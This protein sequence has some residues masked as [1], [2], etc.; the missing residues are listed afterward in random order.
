VDLDPRDL[1]VFLAVERHGSFGR[2]AVEL[3][4]TQPA[5]SERV[6]HL[7][8]VVGRSL[9]ERTT[10]GASLT[11]A[12]ETLL[13]YARRGVAL[14]EEAVEATR[15]AD[16]VP[17]LVIAV[18]SMFAP[19][20][21]PL[22][23]GALSEL[24]RRVS[25]RDAHSDV[26]TALVLDGSAHVGFA[27]PG[28][29]PPGLRR[30]HLRADPIRCVVA[31]GHPISRARRP[32]TRSLR[33]SVLALNAWGPGSER[34]LERLRGDGVDEWRI[35]Y[36]ADATTSLTLARHHD[37]VAFVPESSIGAERDLRRVAL[38]GLSS[39]TMP[40]DLV[41][42]SSGALDPAIAAVVAAVRDR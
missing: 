25:V 7:E 41:F 2:A 42:R 36:C 31:P 28:A 6:R 35:R 38:A 14:A 5:V 34:F 13:P 33:S 1:Q 12:G 17:S 27:V 4:V 29:T 37:H 21:V 30:V 23:L 16:G 10:R 18:H 22:V 15:A 40:L 24:P 8:R 32:S 3:M 9:F 11:T 20:A 19:R 39:W 26:V